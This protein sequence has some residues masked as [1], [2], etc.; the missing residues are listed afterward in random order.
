LV[1]AIGLGLLPSTMDQT[2]L[3][4]KQKLFLFSTWSNYPRLIYQCDATHKVG[5]FGS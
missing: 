3:F 2:F 5:H 4:L 1:G